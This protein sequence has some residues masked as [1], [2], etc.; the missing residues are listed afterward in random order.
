MQ[1]SAGGGCGKGGH[2]AIDAVLDTDF[3]TFV[4]VVR[5]RRFV[6]CLWSYNNTL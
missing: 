2:D 3:I 5:R 1:C 6:V 4:V